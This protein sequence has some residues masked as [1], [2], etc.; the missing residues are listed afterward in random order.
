MEPL[1]FISRKQAIAASQDLVR[2]MEEC[3]LAFEK[4]R[5]NAVEHYFE[6]LKREDVVNALSLVPFHAMYRFDESRAAGMKEEVRVMIFQRTMDDLDR[7][8]TFCDPCTAPWWGILKRDQLRAVLYAGDLDHAEATAF[9]LL[10]ESDQGFPVGRDNDQKH[11]AEQILGQVAL[12][13]GYKK[14][15]VRYFLSSVDDGDAPV[16]GSFGPKMRLANELYEAGEIDAVL[17]YL[18]KIGE[19][20]EFGAESLERWIAAIRVGKDPRD[21]DWR[22][23]MN[24]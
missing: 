8:V 10:A 1:D 17:E 3:R 6:E 16:L 18:I 4:D 11:F 24:Y 23:Q 21:G 5:A 9:Q 12:R 15:A 14:E 20:W 2:R 13:R 22:S 7:A 19:F